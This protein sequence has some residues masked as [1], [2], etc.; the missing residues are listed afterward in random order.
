MPLII[1]IAV[2]W[3]AIWAIRKIMQIVDHENTKKSHPIIEHRAKVIAKN[4][5]LQ[6]EG[7]GTTTKFYITLQFDSGERMAMELKTGLLE[8]PDAQR[9]HSIMAGDEGV[10]R[11][12]MG[13]IIEFVPDARTSGS[14]AATTA[15]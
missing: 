3:F 12:Q 10:V 2:I 11:T 8:S 7:R 9:Y 13:E 14:A 6:A 4:T 15:S 1:L 5:A